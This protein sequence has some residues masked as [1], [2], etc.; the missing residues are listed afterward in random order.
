[1]FAPQIHHVIPF[2][3]WN[4]FHGVREMLSECVWV[5]G[6]EVCDLSERGV[7]TCRARCN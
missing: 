6:L 4:A 5:R 2:K 1:M 7:R 3:V